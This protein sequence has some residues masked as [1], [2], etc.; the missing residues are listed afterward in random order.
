MNKQSDLLAGLSREQY[1][2]QQVTLEG[3]A[4]LEDNWQ[5]LLQWVTK[6]SENLYFYSLQS[7]KAGDWGEFW[8]NQLL[9]ILT[10]LVLL[11]TDA[12]K[13]QFLI[14]KGTGKEKEVL[15]GLESFAVNIIA[16]LK[17]C[18]YNL[19][20]Y[21]RSGKKQGGV[22]EK[23]TTE[24]LGL[25]EEVVNWH[26]GKDK[27]QD[28]D[29]DKKTL[30]L[31]EEA[32]ANSLIFFRMLDTIGE[33]RN[34]SGNYM[35]RIFA[36]G[37]LE[38]ALVV[39]VIFL[40]N[41]ATRMAVFNRRLGRLPIFYIQEILKGHP[42][43]ALPDHTWI[44]LNKTPETDSVIVP[45]G[46]GF[47]GG[48]NE[49]GSDLR[50]L[51][52]EQM[53]VA[54]MQLDEIYSVL[55]KEADIATSP[56]PGEYIAALYRRPIPLLAGEDAPELFSGVE[57]EHVPVGWMV[58]SPMF[59]LR[60]GTREVELHLTL[61]AEAVTYL[62]R[63]T[64]RLGEQ[65]REEKQIPEQIFTDAFIIKI[66]CDEG[67]LK[68]ESCTTHWEKGQENI[69]IRFVL[70]MG[71]PAVGVCQEEIHGVTTQYPAI[72]MVLNEK[73]CIFPYSW[74]SGVA[75]EK[76]TVKVKVQGITTLKIY[77]EYGE[78]D[79]S[80]PFY[81]FGGE[82]KKGA[83]FA[84]GNYEIAC[85]PLTEVTL[86]YRWQQLPTEEGGFTEHYAN[87]RT[88][89]P[90]NNLSFQV[91][92]EWLK[93]KKWVSQLGTCFLFEGAG[94]NS[95]VKENGT[96][97]FSMGREMPVVTVPEENFV[98]HKA[99][100]GFMRVVLSAPDIGF[101]SELYRQ[102]F[103]K[104]MI[105]N[106]Q[107][108]KVVEPLPA[109]PVTPMMS[110]LELAYEAEDTFSLSRTMQ[111]T[112][113]RF[114]QLKSLAWKPF[115]PVDMQET[116][117]LTEPLEDKAHLLFAFRDAR[118]IGLVRIYFDI[119]MRKNEI[120]FGDKAWNEMGVSWYY[121]NGKD[122][123]ALPSEQ[124]L[125]ENTHVFTHAGLVEL[126]LPEPV[127]ADWLD[128]EGRFWLRASIKGDYRECRLVRGFYMNAV[129][130]VAEGGNGSSL[131]VGTITQSVM[132]IPGIESVNQVV[133]GFGGC[134]P[135]DEKYLSLRLAHRIA[136]RGRAVNPVDFERMALQQFPVLE[137]VKCI[138]VTEVGQQFREGEGV[139][140]VLLV[141]MSRELGGKYPLCSL[142]T[143][144]DIQ[145]RLSVGMSFFMRLEVRN[146]VYQKI[147][148]YCRVKLR[149][150]VYIGAVLRKL[151][152]KINFYIAPWLYRNQMPELNQG[153]SLRGLYTIL[154]NEA[155]IEK[156]ESL[157]LER[158]D[159]NKAEDKYQELK[160]DSNTSV[161]AEDV[162][163]MESV[164]GGVFIPDENHV[165]EYK[166]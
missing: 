23:I 153:I 36:C 44:V 29:K 19:V 96:I 16:R 157:K 10:D 131:P 25:L 120:G 102:L 132:S 59:D 80:V 38:P 54:D 73:G 143:L 8:K 156:L 24:L 71:M 128:S 21:G 13:K 22:Q 72:Q 86:S 91:W 42:Q 85:K 63:F 108:T 18:E 166:W 164:C 70:E 123:Q 137:K 116:F 155:E 61:T 162:V 79:S 20:L 64:D 95:R 82:A 105:A 81:P 118:G 11:D 9:V 99:R 56:L 53:V 152:D 1:V 26:Q 119:T 15:K 146:P 138:T 39:L 139:P 125:Q 67:W 93:D 147:R 78:S 87:Y 149:T 50:Y 97:T 98:L 65:D 75:F 66:S 76:L 48:T 31:S 148:I 12:C 41:Y 2:R 62:N 161:G 7:E 106:S 158:V 115:L 43:Q 4:A 57:E 135:E 3:F 30:K 133:S 163:V 68:A 69:V 51:S 141:V 45:A 58:E 94:P 151:Q 124:I 27:D 112:D 88:Q 144:Q 74:A 110:D 142:V 107:K 121:N 114:Y 122:W 90:I 101:G 34:R 165:I 84:F 103:V 100:N 130:V 145:K 127:S 104:A 5:Q 47:V 136:H 111:R 113:A 89:P 46:T 35:D 154:V 49:D 28:Q 77:S 109:E 126:A 92:I 160:L 83:W 60:E 140:G 55:L 40:K 159:E 37:E 32:T 17:R 33:I 6:M 134:P 117:V 150:A 14:N 129:E 52:V